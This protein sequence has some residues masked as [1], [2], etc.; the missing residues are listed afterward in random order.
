MSDPGIQGLL[1][2]GTQ[3]AEGE[4]AALAAITAG[5]AG[6]VQL[7]K[8]EILIGTTKSCTVAAGTVTL[9]P[10]T[11]NTENE[12]GALPNE[13]LKDAPSTTNFGITQ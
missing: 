8:V 11:G 3:G 5:L 13:Q 4:P 2:M 12:A 6:E 7:T 9:V 1:T 10:F